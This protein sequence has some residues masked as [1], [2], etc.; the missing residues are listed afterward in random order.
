MKFSKKNLL[1]MSIASLFVLYNAKLIISIANNY[2]DRDYNTTVNQGGAVAVLIYVIV[3]IFALVVDKE[4]RNNSA[5][6]PLLYILIIGFI[7]YILRYFGTQ[8]AERISFYF[9]FS[10]LALL[11]NTIKSI[12]KDE[13]VMLRTMII[14][15]AVALLAYR[16]YDSYFVPYMF[17]WEG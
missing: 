7:S 12:V 14:F 17:F 13:R 2:F 9:M 16:L 6:T 11:P 5:Q 8:A 4:I 3:L 15:F 10:Q 1:L